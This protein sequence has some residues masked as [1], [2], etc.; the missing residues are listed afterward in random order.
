MKKI[1][2]TCLAGVVLCLS[3]PGGTKTS[4][5]DCTCKGLQLFGRVQVVDR[6]PDILV[7]VVQSFEDLRV[8]VIEAFP[9]RC[10][11]WQFVESFPGVK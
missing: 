10:G 7:Q 5:T 3:S 8:Q 11:K 4:L 2:I 9:D 6:F 1:L